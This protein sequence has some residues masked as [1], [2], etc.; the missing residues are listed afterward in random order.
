[1]AI[2]PDGTACQRNGP[3]DAPAVVLIHGLGLNR[4][5]WQWTTPALLA[6]GYQVI[7]YDLY[8]HGQ[9]VPPPAPPT[10]TLFSR[11]LELVLAQFDLASVGVAGFSLGGMIARRFAQ[12]QPDK[13]SA[14]AILFS[15]HKRT[16]QAQ[17]A[18]A[19]RVIQA[20]DEGP[21]AT[22][23]AALERWFTEPYR[24]ANPE[25][26]GLVRS[27]VLANDIAIYHTV[28][29]VLAD[30]I[31]EIIAPVPPISCATL[32][33]AGDQDYGNGPLMS[34]AIAAEI[35][36]AETHILKGL[37]H[38]ALVENPAAVNTPLIRFL[39]RACQQGGQT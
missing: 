4:A 21:S 30:G 1:M 22:A 18:I 36:G 5:C 2:T 19:A 8:G 35:P 38:M 15:P 16:T 25:K 26:M 6:A 17:D 11:Q 37:R 31:D 29:Q 32:V 28:Y 33:M 23:N 10:L 9:S 24:Q 39:N 20:R 12:D 7:T 27:W 13:I 14:L 34:Q 3:A